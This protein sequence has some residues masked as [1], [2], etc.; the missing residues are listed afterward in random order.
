MG[1]EF[2]MMF[3]TNTLV[4]AL[5]TEW[6]DWRHDCLRG[7]PAV[8]RLGPF[9]FLSHRSGRC[10]RYRVQH[11]LGPGSTALRDWITSG[12]ARTMTE[13]LEAD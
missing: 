1:S 7:G 4:S 6:G 5:E 8:A 13:L 10:L 3:T 11:C 12:Q 2:T 9:L